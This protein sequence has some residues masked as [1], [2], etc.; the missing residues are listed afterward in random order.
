M[1]SP[2]ILIVDDAPDIILFIESA[3]EE[4]FRIITATSGEIAFEKAREQQPDLI[5]LDILMPGMNGYETCKALKNHPKTADIPVIMVSGMDDEKDEV[6]G[7]EAGA[8]DYIT[9]PISIAILQTRINNQ[10]LLLTTR[11]ALEQA[12]L[13]ISLERKYIEEIIDKMK[14]AYEFNHR[15]I[16]YA[17]LSPEI[18]S[19]DLVLSA[20]RPDDSQCIMV[21]DFTGHGLPAAIGGP[22]VSYIFY[23][24]IKENKSLTEIITEINN[25]LTKTL[26]VNIF[27]AVAIIEINPSRTQAKLWNYGMEDI[28]LLS[29]NKS[30][31]SL[32]SKNCALGIIKK[33]A[34]TPHYEITLQPQ[35]Y[36]YLLTDGVIEASDQKTNQEMFGIER[37]KTIL[38]S[39][40]PL[41]D[42]DNHLK[43]VLKQI[44]KH[45]NF[46]LDFDDMTILELSIS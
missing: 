4:D 36:L 11:R 42:E 33:I 6:I 25:T 21:A 34:I 12:H 43:T 16:R 22:L 17:S 9:K 41:N 1:T 32:S 5:L 45:V 26:P 3:L 29:S 24:H 39:N 10:L 15:Y 20:F 27:M 7:L 30:W 18:N 40:R 37:L 28:L 35:Q 31:Q 46:P 19:G 14:S 23:N 38:Q 8:V 13:K 44:I 2:L